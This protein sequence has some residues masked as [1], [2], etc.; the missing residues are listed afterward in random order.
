M[1]GQHN[2]EFCKSM[3]FF[4]LQAYSRKHLPF[5][6]T[7]FRKTVC[8][9]TNEILNCCSDNKRE[10]SICLLVTSATLEI[11]LQ[12]TTFGTICFN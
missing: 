3:Q 9:N 1:K 12:I 6:Q 4:A 5:T 2:G 7:Y 11:A 8:R 10:L